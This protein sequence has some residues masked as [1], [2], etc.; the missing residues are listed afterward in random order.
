MPPGSRYDAQKLS[1]LED[2]VQAA[3]GNIQD[4]NAETALEA[5]LSALRDAMD[6][7]VDRLKAEIA[8][9]AQRI[10]DAEMELKQLQVV[11]LQAC[12]SHRNH[13]KLGKARE[14]RVR[15]RRTARSC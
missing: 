11:Q 12:R 10:G 1:D 13:V 15:S 14:S 7:A 8:D 9:N 3:E 2:K 4:W 6:A 5:R